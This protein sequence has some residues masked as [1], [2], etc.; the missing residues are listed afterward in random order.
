MRPLHLGSPRRSRDVLDELIE[1][2]ADEGLL[3][4]VQQPVD[5]RR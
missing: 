1:V 2:L 3:V 4:L 5:A